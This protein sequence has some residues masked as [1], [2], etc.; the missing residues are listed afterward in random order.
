MRAKDMWTIHMKNKIISPTTTEKRST[1][2]TNESLLQKE[3]YSAE[4]AASAGCIAIKE[5]RGSCS[6]KVQASVH[7]DVEFETYTRIFGMHLI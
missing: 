3:D 5:G 2:S 7:I 1:K 6:F 4:A